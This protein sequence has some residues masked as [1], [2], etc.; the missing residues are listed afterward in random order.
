MVYIRITSPDGALL[1][2]AAGGTFVADGE[3]IPYS[4]CR[5]VDY[6]NVDIDVCVYYDS[7]AGLAKGLYRV[8]VYTSGTRIGEGEALLK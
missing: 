2:D 6:Q 4:A 8:E 1:A 5:E 7:G 3:T